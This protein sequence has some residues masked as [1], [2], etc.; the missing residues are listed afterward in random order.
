M[1]IMQQDGFSDLELANYRAVVYKNVLDLAQQVLIYMKRIELECVEYSN[2]VRS[3]SSCPFHHTWVLFWKALAEKVLEYRLDMQSA[4]PYFPYEI[5]EAINQLWKD[6]IIPK[7]ID[8]HSND[9][10]LMDSAA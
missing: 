3:S 10:Y 2:R 8:E 5:A 7:I 9:F 1:K 6:P 4:S